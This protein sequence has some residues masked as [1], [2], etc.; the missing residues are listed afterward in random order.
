MNK[1]YFGDNLE[2][3]P[4]LPAKSVDLI[5]LDPPFNSKATYNLLYH[6]PDGKA[7]QSQSQAFE[8]SWRWGPTTDVAFALIMNSGSP[9]AGIISS[10][11]NFMHKSDLMAYLT[12]MTARLLE[13]RRVLKD[14]GSIYLHCDS[15]ASHY[16][17]IIM[18]A[19]FGAGTFQN[20]IV[21]KRSHAHSDGKQ[22]ATHF[23]RVTDTI[24]FYT[25]GQTATWNRQY[26]PYDQEYIDRDY[27][28]VD[29]DGRRYRIDNL[30]GPGGAEKGNPYY[31]VMGVSRYWRYSKEKMDELIRQGRVIQT[32]P[33]AVPQYKRYLDE[34]PGVPLQNL[35]TDL[36]VL[37]N[38]SKEA[39][40]YQTQ[41]PLALLERI[42]NAS[43]K[44]GDIV[45]DP[46]CGCGTAI[47]AAQKLGR[48]WIGI[49]ITALAID[50]VEKRLR[51]M[52]LR[53]DFEYEVDG[54]PRDVVDAQRL[55]DLDE[56]QFQL[57]SIT[58]VDGQPRDGGKKGAD[59]GVDGW[60]YF[61]DD[62]RTVGNAIIS[63]KGGKKHSR[64]TCPRSHRCNEQPPRETRR[65]CYAAQAHVGHAERSARGRFCGSGWKNASSCPNPHHRATV[66]WQPS[67]HAASS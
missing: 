27:R 19:T 28:R 65:L 24:L 1:L 42:I 61:Q 5:Y 41:K 13:L 43:S 44:P 34:M 11:Q 63:V 26:E 16:L 54:I 9:V 8:D 30:Q 57:W 52:R 59:K 2:W 12:M 31:E 22:G 55:F 18:D 4:Q 33:G 21:W 39:L 62:A 49:D 3:L 48:Q 66:R 15:S 35:W 53:R 46:F 38:R 37:N 7:A 10:L 60:I 20:E 29:A 50:V 40:G 36:P 17:K 64:Y 47:E 23:G 58:L 6:S 51:R 14:T 56:H 25:K 45:L 67:R 32:R